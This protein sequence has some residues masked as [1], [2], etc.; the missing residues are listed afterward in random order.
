[1][2]NQF[3]P[4]TGT[5]P[6]DGGF[7]LSITFLPGVAIHIEN[8]TRFILRYR[9]FGQ[10]LLICSRTWGC[11]YYMLLLAIGYSSP[12]P[13]LYH[14]ISQLMEAIKG[15]CHGHTRNSNFNCSP[16]FQSSPTFHF[17]FHRWPPGGPKISFHHPRSFRS[18]PASAPY[19][20]TAV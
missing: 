16:K 8:G 17:G 12:L 13:G 11:S 6:H 3:Y 4:R 9:E 18:N 10:P 20:R 7:Q 2:V 14:V 1:M 5:L 19:D 15:Y